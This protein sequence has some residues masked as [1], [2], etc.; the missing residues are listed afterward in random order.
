MRSASVSEAKNGLSALL[1]EV[2]AGA[3]VVITDR[4]VPIARLVPAASTK[5]VSPRL[6]TLAQQGLVVLPEVQPGTAWLKLP[7][8][9]PRPGPS[10]VDFLLE[11]RREG[12]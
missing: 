4:G 8:P 6:V 11:E 5:G 2:Q 12:R 7:R 3:T 1:R 10:P 9:R